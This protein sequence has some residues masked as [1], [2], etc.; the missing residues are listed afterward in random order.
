MM[1]TI[2]RVCGLGLGI[3]LGGVLGLGATAA[4][5]PV[6]EQLRSGGYVLYLRHFNTDRTQADTD[7][8]HLENCATQRPLSARGREQAEAFG[9]ALRALRIPIGAVTVSPY[10]RTIESAQLGGFSALRA[11]VDLAAPEKL[12]AGETE[13]RAAAL[14]ALLSR[15]PAARTNSLIVSHQP[16]LVDA[17][18]KAFADV[19]EGEVVVFRPVR[20]AAGYRM[21]AR[22]KAPAWTE[23]AQAAR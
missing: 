17:A 22:V 23:W 1:S 20:G 19:D 5:P 18:G 7:T 14:R 21:V 6:A 16:N 3:V 11:T 9:A 15:A 4:E 8:V 12:P 13:R 2:A 10:C